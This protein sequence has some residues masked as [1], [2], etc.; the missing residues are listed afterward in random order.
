MCFTWNSRNLPFSE[1]YAV[2]ILHPICTFLQGTVFK[3]PSGSQIESKANITL[4]NGSCAFKRLKELLKSFALSNAEK[5]QIDSWSISQ[6]A[7]AGN[8]PDNLRVF[9]EIK[10]HLKIRCIVLDNPWHCVVPCPSNNWWM[11]GNQRN[12]SMLHKDPRNP[13]LETSQTTY[14]H[15][16]PHISLSQSW[17]S[18]YI[19][20]PA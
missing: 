3:L 13:S 16:I 20:I 17:S 9:F 4:K 18:S 19:C 15:S 2:E 7:L 12:N 5:T 1:I 10:R 14:S 6:L 11:P 8:F